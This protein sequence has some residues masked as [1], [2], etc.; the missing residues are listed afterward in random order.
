MDISPTET[1]SFSE[2]Y[3]GTFISPSSILTSAHIF[4]TIGTSTVVDKNGVSYP[5]QLNKYYTT[6]ASMYT[7]YLGLQNIN[8]TSTATIVNVSRI[9]LV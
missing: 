2:Y 3:T 7:V 9:V 4:V 5:V 8:D 6:L 1:Q